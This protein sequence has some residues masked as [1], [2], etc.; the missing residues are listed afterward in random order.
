[1]KWFTSPPFT[2]PSFTSPWLVRCF[3]VLLAGVL[4]AT[5][6]FWFVRLRE[7]VPP[8]VPIMPAPSVATV[9]FAAQARLFGESTAQ[10]VALP[11]WRLGGVIASQ[12]N[13]K[14]G[15]ALLAEDQKSMRA[16][17]T[18]QQVIPGLVLADVQPHR[19]IL[20]GSQGR[21][22]LIL[23]KQTPST[24][25]S[26]APAQATAQTQPQPTYAPTQ[27]PAPGLAPRRYPRP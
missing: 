16:Y 10:N 23:P 25:T 22:E 13:G 20:E 24:V 4:C 9:D 21:H 14:W 3:S 26:Q 19:V 17:R 7:P 8:V 11:S 15:I 27:P 12:D 18:G 1:M 2:S 6:S 5:L